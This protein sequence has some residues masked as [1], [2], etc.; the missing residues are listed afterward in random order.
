MYKQIITE[1]P[2]ASYVF[3]TK[4]TDKDIENSGREMTPLSRVD[5]AIS[6]KPIDV[7][8][9]Q[10]IK[11]N[12][13]KEKEKEKE[14]KFY[15]GKFKD[16][17]DADT[18]KTLSFMN[19]KSVEQGIEWYRMFDPKIPEALLP[20]MARYNWGDLGTMTKKQAKNLAKKDKKKKKTKKVE[21]MTIK[22][23]P[24]VITF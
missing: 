12:N 5:Y 1:D 23:E 20:L 3:G 16:E 2:K 8:E 13:I 21:S 22:N 10:E 18:R 6:K 14:D 17:E 7:D 19:V 24:V 4:G 11:E 9:L 15:E